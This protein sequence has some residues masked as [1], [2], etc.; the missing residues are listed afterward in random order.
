[1]I[2]Q[3]DPGAPRCNSMERLLLRSVALFLIVA[4]A[5]CVPKEGARPMGASQEQTS[6]PSSAGPPKRITAVILSDLPTFSGR[7]N[8]PLPGASEIEDLVN[9]GLVTVDADDVVHPQLGQAVPSLDNGLWKVSPT[10]EMEVTWRIREGARWHD[11]E[12]I[13]AADL[14]FTLQVVMDKE[15]PLWGDAVYADIGGVEALD[16]RTV[17]VRWQRPTIWADQLFSRSFAMLLPKHLLEKSYTDEKASFTSLPYWNTAFVGAGPFKVREWSGGSHTVLDAFREYALGRPKIDEIEI[18]FMQDSTTVMANILSGTIDVTV[19]RGLSFD[20]GIQAREQF[21]DGKVELGLTSWVAIYPQLVTP[22]PPILS[23]VQFRQALLH[24]ID[25][26]EMAQTI[27]SGLSPVAHTFL[28]PGQAQ[29]RDVEARAV[30]YDYDVRRTGQLIEG[31]GYVRGADGGYRD[32]GG[33]RLEFEDRTFETDI[34]RKTTFATADYWQRAG[35][36]VDVVV[37]PTA[38]QRE[39]EYMATY[40]GITQQ[41]YL[42]DRA[43]A[44]NMHSSRVPGPENGF[45]GAN[46]VRYINSGLDSLIERYFA[47]IPVSDRVGVMEQIVRHVTENLNAMGIFYD[48]QTVMM[49][50]RMRNVPANGLPWNAHEWDVAL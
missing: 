9:A 21:R 7:L 20:Q 18:K 41:R 22:D 6:S 34:N 19:G 42:F 38:R 39:R 45:T 3:P 48:G 25:R 33:R 16:A 4:S 40:P 11:G 43:L 44:K 15:L 47:T 49:R 5:A 50:N 29:Y 23:N 28:R 36:G 37:V 27:Q 46:N 14:L 1:M 31:L 26:D 10:G 17:V 35:I 30:R 24:A 32:A 8:S 13:S 12:A 2:G